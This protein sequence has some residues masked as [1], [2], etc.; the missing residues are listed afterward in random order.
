[1]HAKT[2]FTLSRK[3]RL[4]NLIEVVAAKKSFSSVYIIDTT[5]FDECFLF[6]MITGRHYFLY[7]F[8]ITQRFRTIAMLLRSLR[9]LFSIKSVFYIRYLHNNITILLIPKARN[10]ASTS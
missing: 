2:F 3:K 4:T 10:K 8:I 1:M 9:Q 5:C 6:H 7:K